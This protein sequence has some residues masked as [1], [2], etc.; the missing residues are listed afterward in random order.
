M[1]VGFTIGLILLCFVLVPGGWARAMA[2]LR[3]R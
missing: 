3:R 2:A 1:S